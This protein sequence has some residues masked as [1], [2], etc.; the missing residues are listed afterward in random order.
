MHKGLTGL[1][2]DSARELFRYKSFLLLVFA[3]ICMDR[4]IN[5]LAPRLSD[6]FD[7][8]ASGETARQLARWVFTRLPVRIGDLL[9][10][11]R[12]FWV[13]G[14]LFLAKQLVSMWP[15]SDMRRMH[16]QERGR[17]GLLASLAALTGRQVAWDALAVGTC[18]GIVGAWGAAVFMTARFLWLR[19]PSAWWL[20]MVVVAGAAGLPLAMAGFSYSSKIAVL[21]RGSFTEKLGLFLKLYSRWHVLWPS[22]WFFAVRLLVESVFVAAIPLLLLWVLSDTWVRVPLAALVATPVY[23]YLKMISFKFFLSLYGRYDVVR[24]EYPEYFLNRNAS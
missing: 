11:P 13:L 21:S 19:W 14:I 18:L 5:H 9:A 4:L 17:F 16:R 7:W 1:L 24:E 6:P 23:S 20:A 15:S 3:L 22:W 12:T 8:H 10:N 2:A